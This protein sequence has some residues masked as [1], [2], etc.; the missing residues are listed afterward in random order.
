M[1]SGV[2]Q[3]L[4]NCIE[5]VMDQD[6]EQ[7]MDGTQGVNFYHLLGAYRGMSAALL[8]AEH[9][10]GAINWPRWSEERFS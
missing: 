3:Q 2:L 1:L 6:K 5:H 4:E 7:A 8:K 10:A 9:Q